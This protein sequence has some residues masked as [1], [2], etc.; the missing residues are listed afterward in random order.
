MT[1]SLESCFLVC[2]HTLCLHTV[3]LN[4]M[5]HCVP[6][7]MP[8]QYAYPQQLTYSILQ[9]IRHSM[10]HSMPTQFAYTV[11]LTVCLTVYLYSEPQN[12]YTQYPK[13]RPSLKISN[14]KI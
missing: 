14:L 2:L 6:H 3:C 13:H 8:I 11:Y 1:C 9:S 10:P 7:S 12:A 5:P 4:S